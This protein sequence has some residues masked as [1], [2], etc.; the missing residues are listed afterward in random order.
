LTKIN[1]HEIDFIAKEYGCK[2]EV[3]GS[4]HRPVFLDFSID[5]KLNHLMNPNLLL[6]ST[7]Q[8]FGNLRLKSFKLEFSSAGM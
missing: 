2:E 4:D 5:L 7:D 6:T 3:F 8:G 1:D